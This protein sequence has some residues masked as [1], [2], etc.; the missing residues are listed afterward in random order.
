MVI[1]FIESNDLLENSSY[2]L[3]TVPS[4]MS[5]IPLLKSYNRRVRKGLVAILSVNTGYYWDY[6]YI[7]F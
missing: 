3:S 6:E 7:V 4:E 2:I 5:I 1:L